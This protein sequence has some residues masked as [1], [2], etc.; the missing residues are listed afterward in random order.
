MLRNSQKC[1][2]DVVSLKTSMSR[3][4]KRAVLRNSQKKWPVSCCLVLRYPFQQEHDVHAST[5]EHPPH[6]AHK[7]LVVCRKKMD[8]SYHFGCQ[9]TADLIA[10]N[11]AGES[12]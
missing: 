4:R 11:T 12:V 7:A 5:W 2:R 6:V 9:F 8:D 10:M 1:G 3:R